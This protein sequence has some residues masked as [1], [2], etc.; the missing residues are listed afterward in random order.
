MSG[1]G[2]GRKRLRNI[3][4]KRRC[5]LAVVAAFFQLKY[6]DIDHRAPSQRPCELRTTARKMASLSVPPPDSDRIGS[7]SRLLQGRRA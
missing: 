7:E 2:D 5:L 4:P 3:R 6:A 1:T